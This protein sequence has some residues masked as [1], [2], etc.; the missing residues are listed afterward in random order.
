M[1]VAC[2]S[3]AERA[4]SSNT[5]LIFSFNFDFSA[6][7]SVHM[8]LNFLFAHFRF[9]SKAAL[10]AFMESLLLPHVIMKWNLCGGTEVIYLDPYIFLLVSNIRGVMNKV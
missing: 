4:V 10:R 3:R 1:L 7:P 8:F 5:I 9:S 6:Q 2:L